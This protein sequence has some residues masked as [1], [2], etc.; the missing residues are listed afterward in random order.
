MKNIGTTN[1]LIL[2][3]MWKTMIKKTKLI[4]N[5]TPFIALFQLLYRSKIHRYNLVKS[6]KG[7]LM[8]SKRTRVKT[9]IDL[10]RFF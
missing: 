7:A 9:I 8:R 3:T 5:S 10:R 6:R 1:Y 4:I 2:K